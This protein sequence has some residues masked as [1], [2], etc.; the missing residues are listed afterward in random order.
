MPGTILNAWGFHSGS[1]VKKL[2]AN[3]GDKR[4]T[5]SIPGLG[6]SPGK[7]IATHSSVLA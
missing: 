6:K 2:P 5:G 1:V 3:E 7:D 4:D